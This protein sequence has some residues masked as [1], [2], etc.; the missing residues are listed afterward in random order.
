VG[1]NTAV[2][3]TTD[4]D[5]DATSGL[6]QVVTLN[7]VATPTTPTEILATNN[8]TVDGGLIKLNICVKPNAGQDVAI[9]AGTSTVLK[10]TNPTTGTWTAAASN[11]MIGGSLGTTTAG[12]ATVTFG[13]LVVGKFKYIYTISAGCSDTVEITVNPKP[14]ID[15][16]I[17]PVC[18]PATVDLSQAF[19]SD[20]SGTVTVV[21]YFSTGADAFN[22]TNELTN[23]VVSTGGIYWVRGQN[24][25][26][27]FD[28]TALRVVINPKP[29][30]VT[31]SGFPACRNNGATYTIKFTKTP[32][33]ATV[34]AKNVATGAAIAVT[35]D[36]IANI[37]I[38]VAKVR[39]I[40]TTAE[41][42]KDSIEVNAPACNQP[43]GSIGNFVWKDANDNGLQDLP[44]EKG[45]KDVKLNLYAA[46]GGTKM[47]PVLD[48]KI[49]DMNGGYLFTGLAAGSY[50]VEIDKTTLPDT[51]A[52]TLK[53]DVNSNGNDETDSD[54]DATSGLSQVV[55]L[56][57]VAN[58]TTPTEILA[59]NNLTVDGGL[60]KVILCPKPRFSMTSTPV[61]SNDNTTYSVSIQITG[62]LGG[63]PKVSAGTIAGSN[64][65]TIS[66]I[67]NGVN[68]KITDSL[69][70]V[71][72]YDTTITGINC[73]CTPR[74]PTLLNN[75]FTVCAGDTFPTL[76][77]TVVGLATVEWFTT[78]T[79]GSP[80]FTGLNYKPLGNVPATG[81]TLYAQAR[82]TD[83][84]CPV[85]ISSLRVPAFIVAQNCVV[86]IDLA[87]KKM[88]NK[89]IAQIGDELIYTIKVFNQLNVA[90]T[91]V[92]VKDTIATSVQ[93]VAN[94]F[95]ASRGSASIS[96]N[97]ITWNIGNIN[98]SPDTVTLTYKVKATQVGLH[99]NT[100]EISKTNEKDVDSTP[101]NGKDSED[102]LDRQCFTVPVK[103]CPGEKV[104]VSV[105][106]KYTGVRWF[107]GTQ[108]LTAFEGQNMV[109]L[110]AVGEYTYTAT[111][112]TCPASGC[113][114]V[115]I[116]P[117]D[118]CCP[119]QLCVPV[120]IRARQRCWRAVFFLVLQ[121][122]FV[123][124]NQKQ[125]ECFF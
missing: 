79:G 38:S 114:P 102:D 8:L 50:I 121:G 119:V 48:T 12:E 31:A 93:F 28:T 77:A 116:Q 58:P 56:N 81:D 63:T 6:S 47:G 36:S 33:T 67:P 69:S 87:L 42:C 70:A 92:E 89:K 82:S 32:S 1:S 9:C 49:T 25:A 59:T 91:G 65:Y 4:S 84:L 101:G 73:N 85:A 18:A 115:I 110:D 107:K 94:S 20:N 3:D 21:K 97:V 72:K 54:F 43:R 19:V 96:G 105:P 76:K 122:L 75:S 95:S 111:N 86:E 52:I 112:G 37:A 68:V 61:C 98:A 14:N 64:P 5:F 13:A 44:T 123:I 39:L 125:V 16:T 60:V 104:Q 55:T 113:C 17:A 53:K 88:I 124:C 7:P 26:G 118:N 30:V 11:P 71:C 74:T 109:L 29:T 90:A 34:R 41:G 10:G 66:G 22:N 99:F 27:C 57:P 35:G 51:C 40:V 15:A 2:S 120:T 117:S 100:A 83:P 80:V 24:A 45:V 108:E 106:A 62:K 103:L 23:L 46:S 78:P